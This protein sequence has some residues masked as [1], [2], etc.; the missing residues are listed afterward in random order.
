M[1]FPDV[2]QVVNSEKPIFNYAQ[3]E[4]LAFTIYLGHFFIKSRKNRC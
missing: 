4:S 2:L 1:L 3:K